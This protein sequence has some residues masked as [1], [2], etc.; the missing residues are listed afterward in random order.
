M[1]DYDLMVVTSFSQLRKYAGIEMLYIIL[2]KERGGFIIRGVPMLNG[3]FD[4]SKWE[5]LLGSN[6]TERFYDGFDFISKESFV[7]LLK[8]KYE[9]DHEWLFWNI[10]VLDGKYNK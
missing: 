9:K 6:E 7:D 4:N 2:D 3:Y 1:I 5:I 10:E 8:K